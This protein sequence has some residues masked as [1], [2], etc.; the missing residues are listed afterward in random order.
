MVF[1][2]PPPLD[3]KHGSICRARRN[4]PE[5]SAQ[6]RMADSPIFGDESWRRV[7]KHF[8]SPSRAL[9]WGATLTTV[10]IYLTDRNQLT[11]RLLPSAVDS[12]RRKQSAC[13]EQQRS[14]SGHGF[15]A[16]GRTTVVGWGGLLEFL[17]HF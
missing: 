13:S 6:R 9:D 5:R 16:W 3:G 15:L 14:P 2:G 8:H 10:A 11:G 12:S 17:I 4:H 1:V 7:A